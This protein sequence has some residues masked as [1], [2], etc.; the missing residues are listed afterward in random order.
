[1][2]LRLRL[3]Q[4]AVFHLICAPRAHEFAPG[5]AGSVPVHMRTPRP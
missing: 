4:Q 3:A 2:S 5:A 1:M